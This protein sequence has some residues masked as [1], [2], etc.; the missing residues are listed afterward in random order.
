MGLE[1]LTV[2]RDLGVGIASLII[3][4]VLGKKVTDN[5]FEQIEE[6]NKR[7]EESH[8]QFIDFIQNAYKENTKAFDKFCDLFNE[9]LKAKEIT[10]NLLKEQQQM[11]KEE[12]QNRK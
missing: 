1:D 6:A 9:H 4:Y 5:S 10:F 11:L 7:G 2:L 12:I 3:I 8:K